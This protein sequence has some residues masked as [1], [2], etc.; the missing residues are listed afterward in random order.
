MYYSCGLIIY[1]YK[2][3]LRMS[4]VT[5][6]VCEFSDD[7]VPHTHMLVLLLWCCFFWGESSFTKF[8][9][10]LEIMDTAWDTCNMAWKWGCNKFLKIQNLIHT[11]TMR[12][13]INIKRQI[14]K[15]KRNNISKLAW[16]IIDIMIEFYSLSNY[17]CGIPICTDIKVSKIKW[18][19]YNTSR[20][21]YFYWHEYVYDNGMAWTWLLC[22]RIC[23]SLVDYYSTFSKWIWILFLCSLAM[24]FLCCF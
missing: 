10:V 13:K 15:W 6:I 16:V 8:M 1:Q 21:K 3:Q 5:N 23:A 7:F 12:H 22:W 9:A 18:K 2:H 11:T 20:S 17:C 24:T 4:F 19:N 14:L